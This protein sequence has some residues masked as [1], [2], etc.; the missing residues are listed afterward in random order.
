M[1]KKNIYQKLNYFCIFLAKFETILHFPH[2]QITFFSKFTLKN[3]S[4]Q[5]IFVNQSHFVNLLIFILDQKLCYE[6]FHFLFRPLLI[7]L[8]EHW[9]LGFFKRVINLNRWF[10]Q[11]L[12]KF[13]II[14]IE[15]FIVAIGFRVV[16]GWI[17]SSDTLVFRFL[18]IFK[19]REIN[20]LYLYD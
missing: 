18:F 16:L 13:L 4:D 5:D 10:I 11:N 17:F 15:L 12:F 3:C 9:N 14:I 19:N 20:H 1:T 2:W 7:S 8:R 6:V